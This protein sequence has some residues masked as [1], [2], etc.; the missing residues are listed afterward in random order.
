MAFSSISIPNLC[1]IDSLYQ[2]FREDPTQVDPSWFSFFQG[3]HL[4]LNTQAITE[5][6]QKK[7]IEDLIDAYR[8]YGYLLARFNPITSPPESVYELDLKTLGFTNSE[9]D[10]VFPSCN[11]LQE[12]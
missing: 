12:Q 2:K 10:V 8:K 6:E 7:R 5:V 11:L 3:M 1:F 9:L 4:G